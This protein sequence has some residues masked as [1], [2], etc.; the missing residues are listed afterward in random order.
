MR[1]EGGVLDSAF[2]GMDIPRRVCV[3]ENS[4]KDAM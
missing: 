3:L 4:R 1:C 2:C